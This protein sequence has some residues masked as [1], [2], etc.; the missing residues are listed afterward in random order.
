VVL[1]LLLTVVFPTRN[2]VLWGTVVAF[3]AA[4][5]A[6]WWQTS[7]SLHS[8]ST[9]VVAGVLA[10]VATGIILDGHFYPELLRY[11]G[12]SVVPRMAVAAGIPLDALASYHQSGDALDVYAGH[13]VPALDSPAAVDSLSRARGPI[14]LYTDST[15]RVRLDSAG[16]AYAQALLFHHFPV[17]RLTGRFLNRATRS[18]A[19]VPV[20]LL[21]IPATR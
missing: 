14:W 1:V 19:L 7:S 21:R 16:V 12:T 10:A 18:T 3:L 5:V 6:I 13:I 20:Y 2:P 8:G 4:L 15:G 17:S 11:Q 9:I